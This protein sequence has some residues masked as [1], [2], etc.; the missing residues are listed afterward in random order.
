MSSQHT[1]QGHAHRHTRTTLNIGKSVGSVFVVIGCDFGHVVQLSLLQNVIFGRGV[2]AEAV[3]ASGAGHVAIF[4]AAG[5]EF[6]EEEMGFVKG[7]EDALGHL[8]V[9]VERQ[10]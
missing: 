6:G 2:L 7:F 1:S 3:V 4:A 8:L 5:D 9:S 10:N